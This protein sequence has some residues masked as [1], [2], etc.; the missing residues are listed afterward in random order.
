MN[1]ENYFK[2]LFESIPDYKKI[3]LLM[4]L[5]QNDKDLLH[6]VAFSERDTNRLNKEFKSILIEQHKEYLNYV[7]NEEESIIEK[8]LNKLLEQYFATIFEDVRHERSHIFLLSLV[9]PDR[10]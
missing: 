6:E 4:I 5:Y 3:L 7:K 1:Y 2:G 10:L 9:E 8:F